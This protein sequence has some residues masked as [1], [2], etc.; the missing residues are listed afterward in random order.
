MK[1]NVSGFNL[2]EVNDNLWFLHIIDGESFG[3]TFKEVVLFAM[4]RYGFKLNDV[5][6]A[7]QTMLKENHNAAH[8]GMFGSFMFS[9]VYSFDAQRKAC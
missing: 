9:Y 3:G 6:V 1:S 5:D 8:F 2:V 4:L 7:I